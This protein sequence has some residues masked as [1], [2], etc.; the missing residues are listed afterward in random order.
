MVSFTIDTM[1]SSYSKCIN[2]A[3]AA[4]MKSNMVHKHGCVIALNGKVISSGFNNLRNYSNDG[5]I[6]CCPSC[7]AEISAIRK[8]HCLSKL[9]GH[10]SSGYNDRH[11]YKIRKYIKKLN[12]FV[13]RI[14]KQNIIKSSAPC[15]YCI[16]IIKMLD[17]NKI[18]YSED[19]GSFTDCKPHNYKITHTSDAYRYL[20]FLKYAKPGEIFIS[21]KHM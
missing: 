5:L 15:I 6:D 2:M 9:R 14:N 10:Y 20:S 1:S 19:N 16:K 17:F 8:I 7:H 12:L 3:I 21:K 13:V 4:A 18:I 11:I